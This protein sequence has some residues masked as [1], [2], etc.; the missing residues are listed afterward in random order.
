MIEIFDMTW[1]ACVE[2]FDDSKEEL[3]GYDMVVQSG[4]M[5]INSGQWIQKGK[6]D[7]E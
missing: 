4:D 7:L 6:G 3:Y 5:L 1:E 2:L